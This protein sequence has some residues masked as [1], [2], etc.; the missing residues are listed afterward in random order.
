MAGDKGDTARL[1][2]KLSEGNARSQIYNLD[3]I[4]AFLFFET[5]H[6]PFGLGIV[7][8]FL[9]GALGSEGLGEYRHVAVMAGIDR[10]ESLRKD[11][12]PKHV[13]GLG[14]S[15]FERDI[16]AWFIVIGR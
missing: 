15:R 8:Q 2:R 5:A 7:G 4:A 9:F 10:R 3:K 6:Q 11:A 12:G 14:I 13:A 16:F 1:Y